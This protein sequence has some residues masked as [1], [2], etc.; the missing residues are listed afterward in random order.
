[1]KEKNP[2]KIRKLGT[3]EDNKD[4]CKKCDK[5]PNRLHHY[6]ET[7]AQGETLREGFYCKECVEMLF[8]IKM[9]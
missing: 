2:T 3:L 7:D 4:P 6:R 5:R 1:M 8:G 9:P